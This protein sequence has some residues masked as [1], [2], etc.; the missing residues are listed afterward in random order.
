MRIEISFHA[1]DPESDGAMAELVGKC[2]TIPHVDEFHMKSSVD[3]FDGEK[4]GEKFLG[5]ISH[6]SL[7][8]DA[9]AE[10]VKWVQA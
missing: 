3:L 2:L 6:V 4:A 10:G 1:E 5:N 7:T 9:P 8:A